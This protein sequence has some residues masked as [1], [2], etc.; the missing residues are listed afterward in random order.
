VPQSVPRSDIGQPAN[1]VARDASARSFRGVSGGTVG[2]AVGHRLAP[3]KQGYDRVM[4]FGRSPAQ[5]SASYPWTRGRSVS[6]TAVT[7]TSGEDALSPRYRGIPSRSESNNSSRVSPDAKQPG[8]SATLAQ[9]ASSSRWTCAVNSIDPACL[10]SVEPIPAFGLERTSGR[11]LVPV[12]L[13]QAKRHDVVV[14][15]G[16]D[17]DMAAERVHVVGEGA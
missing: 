3:D 7:R 16:I 6:V 15:H 12:L 1:P 9:Y 17:L 10:A 11:N 4:L 13:D 5:A 14:K 2:R 8:S